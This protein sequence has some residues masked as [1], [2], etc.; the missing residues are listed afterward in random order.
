M[1]FQNNKGNQGACF[2]ID[3]FSSLIDDGSFY[4]RNSANQGGVIFAINDSSFL[5][6][7]VDFSKNFAQESG[8]VL[9]AMYNSQSR[10]LSFDS[11]T[12][13]FNTAKQNL[14]QL[15]SSEAYIT[16]S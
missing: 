1:N 9:Y 14:I 10:A 16:N 6:T 4:Q 5:F 7:N 3:S 15:M 11:C 8:A 2:E 12:F 13:K